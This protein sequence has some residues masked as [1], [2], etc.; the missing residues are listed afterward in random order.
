MGAIQAIFKFLVFVLV[1]IFGPLDNRVRALLKFRRLT[2]LEK[3][4]W[5]TFW[6]SIL[7]WNFGI[8]VHVD[9]GRIDPESQILI[10]NHLGYLDIISFLK[11]SSMNFVSKADVEKW[12]LV[13]WLADS[14]GTLFLNRDKK[15]DIPKVLNSFE[16]ILDSGSR[17]IFFPEGTS[18]GG[19][20]VLPFHS[21]LFHLAAKNEW[22]IQTLAIY[23]KIPEE[24]E[25]EA[26]ERVCY[27]GDM[28]FVDHFKQMILLPRIDCHIYINDSIYCGKNRKLLAAELNQVVSDNLDKLKSGLMKITK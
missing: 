26:S 25:G 16:E 22:R 4:K 13:G 5:A 9:G 24:C 3:Y 1:G 11:L 12:P 27:W 20:D 7:R 15:S 14:A 6:A 21:S 18:S 8:R 28:E 19:H 17:V 2:P 23:F 10:S